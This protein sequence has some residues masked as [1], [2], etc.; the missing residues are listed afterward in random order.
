MVSLDQP[1][2]TS[3]DGVIRRT[4]DIAAKE[5]FL[6]YGSRV[7]ASDPP[8][9][10]A[11]ELGKLFAADMALD[12]LSLRVAEREFCA[13]VGPSGCGKTTLLLIAAGLMRPNAGQI[14]IRGEP[15]NGPY[16]NAGIAFQNHNLL[17]WRTVIGNVELP[18][19]IR[20]TRSEPFL[21]RA[22]E[23]IALVGLAGFERH[24]PHQLSGGMRQRAALARALVC[25]LPLL[26]MDEPFGGLDALTREEHQ[27]L[28]QDVWLKERRTVL[29]ITHDVREAIFLADRVA[30][31]SPRPG[32]IVDT[33]EIALPR[34]REPEVS[35]SQAF[36]D[37]VRRIRGLLFAEPRARETAP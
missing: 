15:V 30:V 34:P 25:D 19:E 28:L 1:F 4:F 3:R 31:M 2:R 17:D 24:Y 11:R 8:F 9:I 22:R 21:A 12:R 37:Y 23:L 33:I 18:L 27:L 6:P 20:G 5:G 10:E 13:I 32:R 26:L 36:N 16:T 14:L 7:T 35:G 29:F